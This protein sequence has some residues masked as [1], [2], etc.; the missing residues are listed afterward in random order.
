VTWQAVDL[1]NGHRLVDNGVGDFDLICERLDRREFLPVMLA[2]AL[3]GKTCACGQ[4][5]R[6]PDG[7]AVV[8]TEPPP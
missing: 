4:V 7:P 2:M 8:Y 1:G 5:L 3:N 6:L